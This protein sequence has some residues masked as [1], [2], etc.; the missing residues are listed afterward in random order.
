M[1]WYDI[2]RFSINDYAADDVTVTRDFFQVNAGSI[3]I[4]TP[5]TYTLPVG[6][7][8]YALPING[9]EIDAS[10]GQIKQNEY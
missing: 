4:N 10:R 2:R 7:K 8:R 1:R 3:D 6:S 5:K 9:I